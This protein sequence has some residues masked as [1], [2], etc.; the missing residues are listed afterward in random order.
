M[1]GLS[2]AESSE[3]ERLKPKRPRRSLGEF[4]EGMIEAECSWVEW[5]LEDAF[6]VMYRHVCLMRRFLVLMSG[7]NI[8]HFAH[9]DDGKCSKHR[10]ILEDKR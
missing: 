2:A 9:V 4:M 6:G 1:L 3:F 8:C 5:N 7:M 10:Q